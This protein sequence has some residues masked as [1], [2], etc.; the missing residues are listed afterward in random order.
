MAPL[1]KDRNTV[2]RDGVKIA[3]L[4]A[5][6]AVIFAGGLVVKDSTGYA[7]PGVTGLGLTVL[8]RADSYVSNSG[9]SAG[10][11]TIEVEAGVFK[12][13]NSSGIDEITAADIGK[14]CYL[15]DDQTVARTSGGVSRSG[16]GIVMG[17]ED[18]GVWVKVGFDVFTEGV[19]SRDIESLSLVGAD[20]A[21]HQIVL[22]GTGRIAKLSSVL[23]DALATG[24]ATITAAIDG[25]DITDGVIT[26][27]Q[28]DSAAG[29]VDSAVPSDNNSF[30]DGQ[31]LTLTVGGANTAS[32]AA[33][34]RVDIEA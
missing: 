20:T 7:K 28:T 26:A 4:M 18:T 23:L 33:A 25:T 29:Q 9:G 12:V 8:G 2:K 22:R 30:T 15:V 31:V 16:A 32:V 6:G 14:V 34:V 21:V 13:A 19:T 11:T 24:D 5:A 1:T 17:V 27:A 10:D 3:A